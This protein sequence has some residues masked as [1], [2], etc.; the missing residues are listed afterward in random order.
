LKDCI[1]H[2]AAS[3]TRAH[4][5]HRRE[6]KRVVNSLPIPEG[7]RVLDLA[8]GDG[9]WLRWLAERTGPKG[10]ALGI[11]ELGSLMRLGRQVVHPQH[12]AAVRRFVVS[13]ADRLPFHNDSLD[14]VWCA[15]SLISLPR[16]EESLAEVARVVRPGGYFAILEDDALH[17]LILPWSPDMELAIRQA[18]WQALTRARQGQRHYVARRLE[19]LVVPAGLCPIRRQTI[20]IDR[21]TPL[22]PADRE[23]VLDQLRL[24]RDQAA[25][26]L[27]ESHWSELDRLLGKKGG[28]FPEKGSHL[29]RYAGRLPA[30]EIN[31][32]FYR[33]HKP[34]TYAKWAGSVPDGFQFAVK[35]PKVATH[36]RRLVDAENILDDF[37]V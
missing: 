32:S 26:C 7:G 33:R 14:L 25:E 35:L 28:N 22:G 3:L 37:L 6:F 15:Q 30:V 27:P 2:Y 13:Q 5:L 11:D 18:Q 16:L 23:H 17:E 34:A 8:C 36:E 1:P 29:A 12:P 4:R 21:R 24:L 31:S 10:Q 9:I 19:Q 20:P